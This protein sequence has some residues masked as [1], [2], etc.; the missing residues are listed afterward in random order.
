MLDQENIQ[1][2]F[3]HFRAKSHVESTKFLHWEKPLGS[4]SYEISATEDPTRIKKSQ[5]VSLAGNGTHLGVK[6]GSKRTTNHKYIFMP[7]EQYLTWRL[8]RSCIGKDE[9]SFLRTK[10]PHPAGATALQM[11]VILGERRKVASASA[12]G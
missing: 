6:T 3:C 7:A 8:Q 1:R 10:E 11:H 2:E 9:N 5:Y 12:Q 4:T